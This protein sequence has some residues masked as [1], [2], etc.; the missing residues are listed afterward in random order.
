MYKKI[1][2]P[3]DGSQLAEAALPHA[4]QLACDFGSGVVLLT[5][6]PPIKHVLSV[7]NREGIDRPS[8]YWLPNWSPGSAIPLPSRD[9][10]QRDDDTTSFVDQQE[11]RVRSDLA[12]YLRHA[13]D[14]L[15]GCGAKVMPE[16]SFNDSAADAII[17]YAA[18]N[19]VDLIVMSTHGRGGIGRWVLGSVAEKVLR[20]ASVP[21]LL[22]RCEGCSDNPLPKSS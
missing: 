9:V 14:S 8:L 7:E 13:G 2:V 16:V 18:A 1:L 12:E 3:L 4:G 10:V 22:V 20:S 17:D 21:V 5:V 19:G 6:S 11:E 15:T